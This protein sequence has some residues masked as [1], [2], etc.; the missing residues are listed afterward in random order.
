MP[1]SS[2]ATDAEKQQIR[3]K[4][5]PRPSLMVEPVETTS[6]IGVGI[7]LVG[8]SLVLVFATAGKFMLLANTIFTLGMLV[9]ALGLVIRSIQTHTN[10]MIEIHNRRVES[11]PAHMVRSH[12]I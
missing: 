10:K 11:L 1:L 2:S 9:T 4:V 6:S 12:Q 3:F 8:V 7:A 5:N